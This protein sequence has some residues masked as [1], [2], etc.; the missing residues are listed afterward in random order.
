MAGIVRFKVNKYV[1]GTRS[2]NVF[3]FKP[4]AQIL[5]EG[6]TYWSHN[7]PRGLF[8]HKGKTC[9]GRT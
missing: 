6:G 2:K 7:R 5:F 8:L 1:H 9:A 3:D 4:K